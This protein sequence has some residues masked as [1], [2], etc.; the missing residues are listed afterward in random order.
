MTSSDPPPSAEALQR[1][2]YERTAG[3][4]QAMHEGDSATR[5]KALRVILRTIDDIGAQSVLDVGSGTGNV[6]RWLAKERPS[7]TLR[8]VEPVP[9]LIRQAEELGLPAGTIQL[10]SGTALPF[11]NASIDVVVAFGVLHH[12]RKPAEVIGEMARVA[13]R[14]VFISDNNRFAQG[15]PLARY[16]KVAIHALG[17][18]PTFDLIR[19]RGRGY[20]VSEGDGLY[21]SYSVFDSLQVLRSYAP[22]LMIVELEAASPP[23][24]R[25]SGPLCNAPSVLT[26]CLFACK[27][28]RSDC[29]QKCTFTPAAKT[30]MFER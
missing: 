29:A 2:Y 12:V 14:A 11:E 25:W 18:W 6:L 3:D 26:L 28:R 24:L 27:S 22:E 9:A 30:L 8:G 21:Y 16:V 23:A 20:M 1:E 7:L 17:L 19:T 4:Y 13:R 10:G 15:R 5:D